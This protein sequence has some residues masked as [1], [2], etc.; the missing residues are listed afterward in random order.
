MGTVSMPQGRGSRYHNLRLYEYYGMEVPSNIDVSRSDENVILIDMTLTE[1][2]GA[3][4]GKALKEY[5]DKQTRNDRKIKDYVKHISNSKNGEQLFYEYVMQWGSKEDFVDNPKNRETAKQCL[6]EYVEEFKKNNPQLIVIGAYIHMDEASPHLHLDYVPVAFGY[7]RGLSVRNSL[8]K[9]MKQ[10]GYIPKGKQSKTNNAT[11]VWKASERARFAK[12]CKDHGLQVEDEKQWGRANLSVEEYK[13]ARDKME[14]DLQ[15]EF[16]DKTKELQELET[17]IAERFDKANSLKKEITA[18]EAQKSTLLSE[19]GN[20]VQDVKNAFNS[21][22]ALL[23]MLRFIRKY[24]DYFKYIIDEIAKDF[25]LTQEDVEAADSMFD[26][27]E[28]DGMD[29]ISESISKVSEYDC[30]R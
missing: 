25:T 6:I 5:N 14:E 11:Q 29:S 13:R 24:K 9:A 10:M 3:I 7:K 21:F 12:I 22:T 19:I 8:D 4:F 18:S 16:A 26:F 28:E 17:D 1:A 20:L 27:M 15:A 2:Y 23:N 30:E